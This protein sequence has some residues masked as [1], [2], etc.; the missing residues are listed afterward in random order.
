MDGGTLISG[1][2]ELYGVLEG[3]GAIQGGFGL[4][5]DGRVV[6]GAGPG[7][8]LNIT[9]G[10]YKQTST[11]TLEI[12]IGGTGEGEY[13]RL[14]VL[15]GA[16]KFDGELEVALLDGF[17]PAIGDTFDIL[18]FMSSSGT[19]D[20][21]PVLGADIKWDTTALYTQGVLGVAGMLMG[22]MSLD[23]NVD[24]R[25]IHNFVH[26]L[27]DHAYQAEADCNLDGQINSLDISGC[28]TR[29][30]DMSGGVGGGG[31]AAVPE[32]ASLAMALAVGAALLRRRKAA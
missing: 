9:S 4:Y 12:E 31:A 3:F 21:L 2:L 10:T 25:D 1:S 11:A 30:V 15:A 5:N 13:G 20:R 19:F 8:A 16:A 24:A 18:D 22:D 6:A 28:V 23:G 14:R 26:R 7:T 29:L 17:A 32:P 27:T